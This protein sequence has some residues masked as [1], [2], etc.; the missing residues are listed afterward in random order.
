M[1]SILRIDGKRWA[2]R[3]SGEIIDLREAIELFGSGRQVV[4]DDVL[5][6]REAIVLRADEFEL[7]QEP[8]EV[9]DAAERIGA[10]KCDSLS[11]RSR[12]KAASHIKRP[13]TQR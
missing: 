12:E 6:E 7:L 2:V 3:L 11:G 10:S 13:S 1:P 5:P 8:N 4:R 9:Y